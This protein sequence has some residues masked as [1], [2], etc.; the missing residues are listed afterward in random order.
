ME[1][2]LMC[3]IRCNVDSVLGHRKRRDLC[4]WSRAIEWLKFTLLLR[5]MFPSVVDMCHHIIDCMTSEQTQVLWWAFDL[6]LPCDVKL[7]TEKNLIFFCFDFFFCFQVSF[8]TIIDKLRVF[9]KTA[10][11]QLHNLNVLELKREM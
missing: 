7:P 5:A 8:T 2:F 9:Y 3:W 6:I 10:T 11:K 1:S 4:L